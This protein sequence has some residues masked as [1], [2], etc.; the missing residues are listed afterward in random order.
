MTDRAQPTLSYLATVKVEVSRPIEVGDTA[1]GFRRVVPIAGGSVEG[2]ELK[3]S[4]LPVGADFQL[5]KSETVTELEAK[6]II[7]TDEGEKIYVSNYGIRAGSAEDIAALVR[8]ESVDPERIYFRCSPRM[9]S[10]GRWA[11]LGSRIIV[12]SG[13]R[14]PD[15]VHL[16]FYVLD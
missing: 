10:E 14:H 1:D 12:G 11:W 8:G 5:L 7:E 2:P 16:E 3:G 13:V 9:A 6:Y 15:A 4:V